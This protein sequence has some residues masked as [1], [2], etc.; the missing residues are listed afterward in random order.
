MFSPNNLFPHNNDFYPTTR[1]FHY[2]SL[3]LWW[4]NTD[5]WWKKPCTGQ[6]LEDPIFIGFYT[7]PVVIAGF[8]PSTLRIFSGEHRIFAS[9]CRCDCQ[10]L[11]CLLDT[12]ELC[13]CS[14]IN[15]EVPFTAPGGGGKSEISS[16]IFIPLRMDDF[17]VPCW[18][19]NGCKRC[20]K[21]KEMKGIWYGYWYQFGVRIKLLLLLLL[22]VRMPITILLVMMIDFG[23]IFQI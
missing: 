15:V 2:F 23:I 7:S 10:L 4:K 14:A 5:C 20:E 6:Y 1:K 3:T 17:Q 11:L 12:S 18:F 21:P 16:L 8:V 9:E 13:S 19:A 22:M